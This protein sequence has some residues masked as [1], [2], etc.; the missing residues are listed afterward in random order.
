M[1][2]FFGL[3]RLIMMGKK[4][5]SSYTEKVLNVWAISLILWSIY[6]ANFKTDLPIEFD[7]FFAKPIIFI[8][9]AYIFI[10]KIDKVNFFQAIALSSKNFLRELLIGATIG[11]IFFAAL[12]AVNAG[13]F[14]ITGSRIF[15]T[16]AIALAAAI[17]EE[18]LSRGFVLK[19]LYEQSKNIYSSS[20]LASLLFFFLHVPILFTSSSINGFLLLQVMLTDLV[21]SL[22]LSFLFLQ[23]NNLIAPIFVHAFYT[24]GLLILI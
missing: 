21:L 1:H 4:S 20:F 11:I 24:L 14:N 19:R 7:E 2:C 9:P 18:I 17:S 10:K 22:S 5:K 3:I 15:Y 13:K 12:I 6:R 8:L 23:R 16:L